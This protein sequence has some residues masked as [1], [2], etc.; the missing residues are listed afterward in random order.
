MVI[1]WQVN[2]EIIVTLNTQ[3]SKITYKKIVR[4]R[5]GCNRQ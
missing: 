1:S 3:Y 5:E 2:G 4:K